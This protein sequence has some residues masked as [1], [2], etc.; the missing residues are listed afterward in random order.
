MHLVID[1]RRKKVKIEFSATQTEM[2]L[3]SEVEV[4]VKMNKRQNQSI[5][6]QIPAF[7]A[8]LLHYLTMTNVALLDS[9]YEVIEKKIRTALEEEKND[10]SV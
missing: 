9:T 5:K 7:S 2:G 4:E 10:T 8:K 3:K 1:L 6:E